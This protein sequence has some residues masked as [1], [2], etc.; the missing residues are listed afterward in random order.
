MSKSL[1]NFFTIREVLRAFDP[2]VVRFFLLSTHYRSPIEFSDEQLREI[3]ASIDRCYTAI[4]RLH[5]VL[6][7]EPRSG[8]LTGPGEIFQRALF[9]FRG[10]FEEA[11][12]DDFNTALA[13]GHFFELI[14]ETNKFL[15]SRPSTKQELEL[16]HEVRTLIIEIS[17]VMNVLRKS[18]HDWYV[19]LMRVKGI[20]LSEAEI[21][22]KIA[23]RREAR[24]NKDWS[25]ADE[26]RGELAE[27]GVILEDKKERTDWKIKI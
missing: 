12:D 20:G 6:E 27:K 15:D 5:D 10:R 16:L 25:R 26:I 7:S 22:E 13:L 2:E 24:E 11:M 19:S 23:E 18:P 4:I 8:G 1:G 17:N 14:R 21:Q 9:G 3:E